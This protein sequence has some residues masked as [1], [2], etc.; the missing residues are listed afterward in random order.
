MC[1][2]E[3]LDE[4]PGDR[5][6]KQLRDIGAYTAIPTMLVAGPALGYYLGLQI[7][8]KWGH[9]PWPTSLGVVFGLLAAARQVWLLVTRDGRGK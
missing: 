8:K 2:E 6:G 9:A 3:R 4:R 1:P 5:R 7:E